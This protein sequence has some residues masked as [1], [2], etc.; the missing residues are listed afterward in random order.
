MASVTLFNT[1]DQSVLPSG[2]METPK[3]HLEVPIMCAYEK[4]M[5]ISADLGSIGYCLF[6]AVSER[7]SIFINSVNYDILKMNVAAVVVPD[8]TVT[9]VR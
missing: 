5:L 6:I 1:M 9:I 2:V 4:S 7:C 8:V 3:T